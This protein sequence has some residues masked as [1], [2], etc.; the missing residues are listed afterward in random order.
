MV[1][2]VAYLQ[3]NERFSNGCFQ[4]YKT[5]YLRHFPEILGKYPHVHTLSAA[6]EELDKI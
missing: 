1:L 3:T 4:V 6:H 2:K 5:K